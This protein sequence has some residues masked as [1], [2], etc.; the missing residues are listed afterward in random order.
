[1]RIAMKN[2]FFKIENKKTFSFAV[3]LILYELLY[4]LIMLITHSNLLYTYFVPNSYDTSMDYFN[5]LA[6]MQ[7]DTPYANNSNYPAMCFLFWKILYCLIPHS[8]TIMEGPFLRNYMPAQLGYIMIMGITIILLWELLKSFRIGGK[9]EN[10]LLS[11]GILLSGPII[12]TFERGNII[13]IAF[14]FLLVF[15]R[16]YDSEKKYL[17]IFAYL[18]LA[19]SASLKLYPAFFGILVLHKKRFKEAGMLI[20]LGISLF[21]LPFFAFDGIQSLNDM[22]R[23][24]FMATSEQLSFG[25]GTNYSFNN[26]VNIIEKLCNSSIDSLPVFTTIFPTLFCILGYALTAKQ[27]QKIYM[28]SLSCIWIPTVSYQYLLIL[29]II[30]FLFY[31]K[32]EQENISY[33]NCLYGVLFIIILIPLALPAIDSFKDYKYPLTLPT[34]IINLTILSLSLLILIEAVYK[35]L[36]L[37][38]Y[39]PN[40]KPF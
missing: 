22:L 12:F 36:L 29:F 18:S 24:M 33:F 3:I 2:N 35:K 16:F 8:D 6:N 27:W 39:R 7:Y 19:L 26:L 1:M 23:G 5:M 20:I 28:L 14:L 30:P 37:K 38:K 25:L 4:C 13:S 21:I 40:R 11:A 17:R 15:M 31:L 9:F 34:L 10:I 32:E